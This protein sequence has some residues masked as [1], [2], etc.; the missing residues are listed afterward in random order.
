MESR[1]PVFSNNEGFR[2]GGYAT[3]STPS[4]TELQG[5][6]DAPS[7]TP[8]QTGRMTLDDVV[9]RT[10]TLFSVLVAAAATM[11]FVVKPGLAIVLGAALAGMV[12]GLVISFSKTVRPALILAYGV[13]VPLSRLVA[14]FVLNADLRGVAQTEVV[15]T[16]GSVVPVCVGVVLVLLAECF[17]Q[18]AALRE[19]V[20]GLV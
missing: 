11:Y 1:N 5:M 7:A 8:L 20:E 9:V 6:Y 13:L 16:P 2:R 10:A 18:G 12:L 4:A 17:R 14:D 19:D 3:F 15:L